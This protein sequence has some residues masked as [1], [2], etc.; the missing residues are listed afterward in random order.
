MVAMDLYSKFQGAM[1]LR[2]S[3]NLSKENSLKLLESEIPPKSVMMV[4][5][6]EKTPKSNSL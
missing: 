1:R 6:Y 5:I 2:R 3:E 4:L